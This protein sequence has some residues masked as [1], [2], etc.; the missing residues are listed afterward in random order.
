[1]NETKTLQNLAEILSVFLECNVADIEPSKSAKDF[2]KWDSL[3][4]VK[5]ILAIESEF[6]VRFE[7]AEFAQLHSI[8][9]L[10]SAI[11]EKTGE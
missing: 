11:S 8:G 4:N 10:A 1:M 9:E 2:D 6:N 7:A 3:S 5:I